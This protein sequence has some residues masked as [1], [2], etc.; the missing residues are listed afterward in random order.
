[1]AITNG[2]RDIMLFSSSGKCIRFNENDVRPMGR[3]A[4]GVIGIRLERALEPAEVGHRVTSLCHLAHIAVHVGEKLRWDPEKEVFQGN[5][6]ANEYVSK[7][8]HQPRIT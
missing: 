8:I 4:R 5:D 2:Q 6:A 1:M 3:T 7:P